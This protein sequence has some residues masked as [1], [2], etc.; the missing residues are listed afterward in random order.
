MLMVGLLCGVAVAEELLQKWL[1]P[2]EVFLECI[3]FNHRVVVVERVEFG[4]QVLAEGELPVP[5][6]TRTTA[7]A[8]VG[9]PQICQP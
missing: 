9:G 1:H 8:I 7:T 6:M 4:R 2:L 3:L 5:V